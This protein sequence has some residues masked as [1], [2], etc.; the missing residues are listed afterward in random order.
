MAPS[1]GR[2]RNYFIAGVLT[3]IPVWITWVVFRFIVDQLSSVGRPWVFAL[4][5][6][7]R[8]YAPDTAALLLNPWFESGLAVVLT[9]LALLVLGWAATRVV[10]KRLIAAFDALVHRIPLIEKIYG[11]SKA[12]VSAFQQQPEQVQRVVLIEFPNEGMKTVGLVTRTLTASDTGEELAAVYVP[13]TP[14]PTSGYLE[15]VPV[16][17]L[18]PTDW[19][20]DEAMSFVIS[21]GTVAP[22]GVHFRRKTAPAAPTK[23]RTAS[24]S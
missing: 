2:L 24:S 6:V 21:G 14:N 16:K 9:V 4:S 5:R 19:T 12:V 15:I 22:D 13:T 17:Q 11:S 7:I 20:F 23:E 8:P 10:G 1:T 18:V 3:V